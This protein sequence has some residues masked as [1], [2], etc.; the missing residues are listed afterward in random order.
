MV[1]WGGSVDLFVSILAKVF[2]AAN[3]LIE[4]NDTSHIDYKPTHHL[5]LHLSMD[6]LFLYLSVYNLLADMY[7]DASFPSRPDHR[8]PM[9]QSILPS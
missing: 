4:C 6:C 1:D 5:F 7:F 2:H 8:N 9:V 3:L